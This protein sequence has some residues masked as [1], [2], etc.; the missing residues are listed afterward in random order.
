MV[1]D[2]LGQPLDYPGAQ[3]LL[4]VEG[5]TLAAT[6]VAAGVEPGV[7]Y[8]LAIPLDSGVT[9]DL[10]KPSALR[11][12]V[13]FRMRVKVGS[14]SYLPMEMTGASGLLTQPGESSRVDLTLGIDAD[15]NG[16]PD[17]WERAV[18]EFLGRQWVSGSIHPGDLYPGSNMSYRDVYIAGIY[19]LTPEDGFALEITP[20]A[21]GRARLAFTAVRG[22]GYTVQA[23]AQLGD[24]H[25]VSFR[26]LPLASPDAAA[27]PAYQAA[28]TQRIEIEAPE[29]PGAK[30]RFYR[31]LVQ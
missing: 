3:V 12:T 10:Y 23:A 2:E 18:A 26:L 20:D 8:R 4:E 11:P 27:I 17:A 24:W 9:S 15:G 13:P 1:R 29:L 14:V 28:E 7:N 30:A 31:L 19:N 25:A 5:T 21:G 22:R 6:A 16:L